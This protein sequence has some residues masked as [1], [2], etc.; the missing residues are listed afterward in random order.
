MASGHR[1]LTG[2]PAVPWSDAARRLGLDEVEPERREAARRF[3]MRWTEYYLGLAEAGARPT[4]SAA[5]RSPSPKDRT[6][7][8]LARRPGRR[9]RRR[10]RRLTW[11]ASTPIGRS[12]WSPAR[13][14]VYCRFCF[15]RTFPDGAHSGSRPGCARCRHRLLS[16]EADLREVILSGGD[17]LALPDENSAGSCRVSPPCRNSCSFACTHGRRSTTPPASRRTWPMRSSGAADLG[18]AAFRSP[19]RGH[20]RT[21]RVA[22]LLLERGSRCS[23]S[24]SCWAGSTMIPRRSRSCVAGCGASGSSPTTFTTPTACRA[25]ARSRWRSTAGSRSTG[26]YAD[27]S[28]VARPCRPT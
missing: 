7:S 26:S 21:R 3:P 17:P 9:A 8:G 2:S 11:S 16:G 1:M 12:C 15:R 27:A 18:G 25:R 20:R 19:A 5:S 23:T 28:A 22:S 13:C 4:R 24:G 14:H 10:T 6:G